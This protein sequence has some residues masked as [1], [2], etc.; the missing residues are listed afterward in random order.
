MAST[1]DLGS[2]VPISLYPVHNFMLHTDTE[3]WAKIPDPKNK[4]KMKVPDAWNGYGESACSLIQMIGD[5]IA[6]GVIAK[7]IVIFADR[8]FSGL[9]LAR[10]ILSKSTLLR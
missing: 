9:K 6:K 4:G 10:W 1:I 2:D 8:A 3:E 7:S 5:M